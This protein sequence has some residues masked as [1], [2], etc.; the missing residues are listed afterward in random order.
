MIEPFHRGGHGGT[1][2]DDLTK[3]ALVIEHRAEIW[4]HFTGLW[5]RNLPLYHLPLWT[6]DIIKSQGEGEGSDG[7]QITWD[8]RISNKIE[9][10]PPG[11]P[12]TETSTAFLSPPVLLPKILLLQ[13][14]TKVIES[15]RGL[16]LTYSWKTWDSI[17][18][19]RLKESCWFCQTCFTL[20]NNLRYPHSIAT[21]SFTWGQFASW[22]HIFPGIFQLHPY[23]L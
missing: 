13:T 4:A 2:F 23:F 8:K 10:K 11:S 1:E 18:G 14:P 16:K 20:H 19:E 22:F 9:T 6:E 5:S 15:C 12:S 21:F 3:L 7:T 17:V